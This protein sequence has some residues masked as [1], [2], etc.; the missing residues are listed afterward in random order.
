[1]PSRRTF[2]TGAALVGV[3]GSSGAVVRKSLTSGRL[4][5]KFVSVRWERD[6]QRYGSDPLRIVH[7]SGMSRIEAYL[8]EPYV[9]AFVPPATLQVS[10]EL[11]D[12]LTDDFDRVTYSLAFEQTGRFSGRV[13]RSDFNRVDVA[14][15]VQVLDYGWLTGPSPNRVA[16]VTERTPTVE[17]R[18]VVHFPLDAW[19]GW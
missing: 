18:N 9:D 7:L 1:M 12:R 16:N 13:P 2:L 11:H 19:E 14:D 4:Y 10:D 15:D 17:E 3:A 8:A 6:G 5:N